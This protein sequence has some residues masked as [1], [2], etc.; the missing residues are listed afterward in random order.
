MPTLDYET[1]WDEVERLRAEIERLRAALQ[2]YAIP[3]NS[4]DDGKRA[5]S[6]LS[7]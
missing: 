6:A 2:F 5:Q 7:E 3:E 4:A 1:V